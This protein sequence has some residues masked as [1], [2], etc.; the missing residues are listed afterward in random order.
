M[1]DEINKKEIAIR[2]VDRIK[3]IGSRVKECRINAK[4]TQQDLAFFC[5]SDKSV[6]SDIETGK[7]KNITLMTIFKI[8]CVLNVTENYLLTGDKQHKQDKQ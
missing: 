4:M 2:V 3:E 1:K 7:A 6:M 5:F 8:S